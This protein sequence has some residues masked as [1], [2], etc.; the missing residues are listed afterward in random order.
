MLPPHGVIM[1]IRMACV[2][3]GRVDAILGRARDLL[4]RV[5]VGVEDEKAEALLLEHGAMRSSDGRVRIPEDLVERSL[6]TLPG[7][8]TLFDRNGEAAAHL[9]GSR[10]HFLPGSSALRIL[11]PGGGERDARREDLD[12]LARIVDGLDTFPVQSTSVVP[13]DVPREAADRTRLY[14]ALRGCR[15]PVVTGTFREDGFDPMV[16]MLESVRG[17]Q[18]ALRDKPL[19]VFDCCP[20]PPLQWSRLTSSA[21]VGAA[22]RGIPATVIPMPLAG[23]TGPVTLEGSLVQI[24]AENLSGIVLAQ[25]AARGAPVIWGGCPTAFDMRRGTTPTGAP[26]TMLLNGASMAMARKLGVPSHGYL[27]LSDSR[28]PD[29]QAGHETAMGALAAALSGMNLAAGA[30]MLRFIECLSLEKL[31]FDAA[32]CDAALRFVRGIAPHPEDD[33]EALFMEAIGGKGFL[34]MRHTRLHH[35]E[36]LSA[37][38]PLLDRSA[39]AEAPPALIERCRETVGRLAGE[40]AE[41]PL[42]PEAEREL[43]RILRFELER[44]S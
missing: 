17:G 22:S 38:D 33:L 28:L 42:A 4:L 23:A 25:C 14:H 32:V 30:G 2:S 1:N 37:G 27:A 11:D 16:R 20:T 18:A 29:M 9:G 24:V 7:E 8:V 6:G 26:E 41:S 15:K 35:R 43:D 10:C 44:Y 3:D 40:E 19:A 34:G 36:E 12:R 5:G 31:V 21:L 13:G 39:A